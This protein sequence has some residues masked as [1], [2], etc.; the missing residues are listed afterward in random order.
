MEKMI[1]SL[2]I[3]VALIQLSSLPKLSTLIIDESFGA[4]DSEN[5]NAMGK[6]FES[7]RDK[8][9]NIII[10]SHIDSIKDMVDHSI[11]IEVDDEG[12]SK[13]LN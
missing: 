13:L 4:L 10:I 9:K 2:A 3:R 12:Y 5:V 6:M 11:T 1:S 8:F 7:L